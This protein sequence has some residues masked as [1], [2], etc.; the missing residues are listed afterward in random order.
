MNTEDILIND[1]YKHNLNIY[2]E[3][4]RITS[5]A[6]MKTNPCKFFCLNF[7]NRNLFI[8]SFRENATYTAVIK[9]LYL[10]MYLSLN[11]FINTF[12]YRNFQFYLYL[13]YKI[14]LHYTH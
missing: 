2:N 4:M 5:F 13:L 3:D 1:N 10:P 8:C 6:K 11:L 9:A 12:I 14:F 7:I